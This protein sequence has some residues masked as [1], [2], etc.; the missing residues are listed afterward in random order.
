MVEGHNCEILW[1][2]MLHFRKIIVFC[3]FVNNYFVCINKILTH[4]DEEIWHPNTFDHHRTIVVSKNYRIVA[5]GEA[6]SL[7]HPLYHY[8]VR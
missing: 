2:W 5:V 1:E 4:C 6:V 7:S 3:Q 8:K